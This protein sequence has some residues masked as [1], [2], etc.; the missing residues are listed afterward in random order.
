MQ[1]LWTEGLTVGRLDQAVSLG[2]SVYPEKGSFN[3][4]LGA[5]KCVFSARSQI[6]DG[7]VCLTLQY[8]NSPVILMG[9]SGPLLCFLYCL[10]NI[11]SSPIGQGKWGEL[12][13]SIFFLLTDLCLLKMLF[14]LFIFF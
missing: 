8:V 1:G 13:I 12:C 5:Y 10:G 4:L 3:F 9:D 2:Q 14:T 7:A 11:Q 6:E